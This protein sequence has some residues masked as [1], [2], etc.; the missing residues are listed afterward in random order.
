[1]IYQLSIKPYYD[2]LHKC[3]KQIYVINTMPEGP[4]KK[5]VKLMKPNKLSAFDDCS[6][7]CD[8]SPQCIYA[9]N[10]FNSVANLFNFLLT[11]N[12]TIDNNIT[13][14]LKKTEAYDSSDLL[15]FISYKN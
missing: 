4:L 5:H 12:Y 3:Y 15:C 6:S 11:N 14:M 8:K 9:I 1:M 13:K 7:C 10:G 2:N